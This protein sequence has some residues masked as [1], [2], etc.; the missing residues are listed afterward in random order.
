MGNGALAIGP[1]LPR[2]SSTL[3]QQTSTPV[4]TAVCST[5]FSLAVR[6]RSARLLRCRSLNWHVCQPALRISA[7]LCYR[8]RR[9]RREAHRHRREA[10]GH[11]LADDRRATASQPERIPRSVCARASRGGRGCLAHHDWRSDPASA[12]FFFQW[13]LATRQGHYR[14]SISYGVGYP[15]H[16][17]K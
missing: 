6:S 14:A 3:P 17:V 13:S 1:K 8:K 2:P 5:H 10:S 7:L 15:G 16:I 11:S 12:D 9:R 4:T